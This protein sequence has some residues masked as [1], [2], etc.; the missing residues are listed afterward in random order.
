MEGPRGRKGPTCSETGK[1]PIVVGAQQI[2]AEGAWTE[3]EEVG[4]GQIVQDL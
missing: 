1:K 2:E 3:V 4:R